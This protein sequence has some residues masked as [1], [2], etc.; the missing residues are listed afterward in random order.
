ML[1]WLTSHTHKRGSNFTVMDPSGTKIYQSNV[2]SDPVTLWLEPP[3]KFD[4]VNNSIQ[5]L[6]KNLDLDMVSRGSRV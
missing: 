1:Y 3:M 6:E 5:Q 2:Y 4:S